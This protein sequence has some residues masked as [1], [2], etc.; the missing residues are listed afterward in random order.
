MLSPQYLISV[1]RDDQGAIETI[2]CDEAD[3]KHFYIDDK[4]V[5]HKTDSGI[6]NTPN[7]VELVSLYGKYLVSFA[8]SARMKDSN[9]K[10][11]MDITNGYTRVGFVKA[12]HAGDSLFILVN[13]FK[14]MKPADFGYG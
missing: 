11:W 4:G 5:A 1:A 3:D 14:N 12:V 9:T 7:K 13:E 8:D 2:P 10:P 6:A